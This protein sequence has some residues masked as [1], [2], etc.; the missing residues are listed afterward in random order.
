MLIPLLVSAISVV[1]KMVSKTGAGVEKKGLVMSL[2]GVVL[3]GLEGFGVLAGAKKA[4]VNKA[5]NKLIDG[6]V[7]LLKALEVLPDMKGGPQG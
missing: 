4:A 3:S 5:V 1:E 6:L 7:D 2:V